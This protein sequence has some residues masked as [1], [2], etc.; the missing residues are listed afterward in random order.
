[1]INLASLGLYLIMV[2]VAAV[3]IQR[4]FSLGQ[5]RAGT[6]GDSRIRY[7]SAVA[8]AEI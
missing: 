5:K 3:V 2:A 4:G 7:C 8:A 1:M 6:N